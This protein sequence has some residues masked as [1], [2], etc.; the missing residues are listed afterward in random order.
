M[1]TNL[2][3]IELT[4]RQAEILKLVAQGET[5][6]QI[7]NRLNTSKDS[8]N[9]TIMRLLRKTATSSRA[10]LIGYA[11]SQNLIPPA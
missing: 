7:A 1:S 9:M 3:K 8:V 10:Q 5:S 4:P 2:L 6:K 11:L